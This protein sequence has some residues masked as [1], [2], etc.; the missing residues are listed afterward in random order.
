[1]ARV[2]FTAMVA[3]ITGKLA[4]SVFQYSYG[5]YQVHTKGKPRNPQTQYQ[6]LRRGDFGF[7]S[8][9]WRSLSSVDRQTFIDNAPAGMSAI[10]F[11]IQC[12][13]NLI[14]AEQP[15]I[16]SY[17]VTSA[18]ASMPVAPFEA[19]ETSYV[20]VATGA[21]TVVPVGTTLVVFSTYTKVPTKIFTNPS[22]YSPIIAFPA[23]TVLSPGQDIIAAYN[24]RF[25]QITTDKQLCV[26]AALIDNTNGNRTDTSPACIIT[27]DMPRQIIYAALV[28]QSGAANPTVV[29]KINTIG[30]VTYTRNFAGSY[31]LG[32]AGLF[33]S[34]MF[35]IVGSNQTPH[36]S[37]ETVFVSYSNPNSIE[38]SVYR[39]TSLSDDVLNN[40]Q[41]MIVIP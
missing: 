37:N 29:E 19:T 2:S 23:G 5:G 14:L 3:E 34:A 41:V 25:G 16:S 9:S 6:Q 28:S 17:A 15:T 27:D 24:A 33:S 13:V 8:A 40:T 30:A 21:T 1:M 36:A 18:P 10:N 31:T 11:F 4:G 32:S 7:L 20:V 26:K 38:F 12:N 35:V 39:A 22:E